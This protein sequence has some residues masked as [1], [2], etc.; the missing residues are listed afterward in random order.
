LNQI[1]MGKGGCMILPLFL[2]AGIATFIFIE[3][4]F[5]LHKS[6]MGAVRFLEGI[7]NLLFKGRLVE[8]ITVCKEIPGPIAAIVRAGLLKAESSE[9]V[10]QGALQSAAL[11]EIPLLERRIATLGA[12]SKIAPLVGFVGTLI[13]LFETFYTIQQTGPY[14]TILVFIPYVIQALLS[15]ILGL[16]VTIFTS[17]SY[18][19]L[20][21]RVKGLVQDMEWAGHT[22]TQF[23][24]H[25]LK[26]SEALSTHVEKLDSDL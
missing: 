19:F 9:A 14:S 11:V 16:I 17:L 3:R 18:T 22:M 25:E 2:L 10:I 26:A 8:A 12:I 13:A 21:S 24:V 5:F 7:K 15:S 20:V 1:F 4:F 23:L 6:H